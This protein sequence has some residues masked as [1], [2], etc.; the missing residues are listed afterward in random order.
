MGTNYLDIVPVSGSP[1]V[2]ASS[3]CVYQI[4]TNSSN[5]I[6]EDIEHGI[7]IRTYC[8]FFCNLP[9]LIMM[10]VLMT[11]GIPGNTL[12]I[13][14]YTCKKNKSPANIYMIALASLDLF[15]CV[16]IHPYI[17]WR[18]F[19]GYYKPHETICKIFE[20]FIHHIMGTQGLVLFAISVDRYICAKYPMQF[21]NAIT[22][23]KYFISAA[24]IVG[25]LLSAPSLWFLGI[26]M[27]YVTRGSTMYIGYRCDY[28]TEYY[29]S[30]STIFGIYNFFMITAFL[31]CC[32][33]AIVLY[34]LLARTILL[35]RRRV[36][37]LNELVPHR[38]SRLEKKEKDKSRHGEILNPHEKLSVEVTKCEKE[39]TCRN[40][41][42]KSALAS[43]SCGNH[44][45]P[46][47]LGKPS[48]NS[49]RDENGSD[50][51]SIDSF[52]S[53]TSGAKERNDIEMHMEYPVLES[54]D[55]EPSENMKKKTENKPGVNVK[56]NSVNF[57]LPCEDADDI[58]SENA[59]SSLHAHA[60]AKR[61][62]DLST[63]PKRISDLSANGKRIGA[64]P[65]H[66]RRKSAHAK[67]ISAVPAHGKRKDI[68]RKEDTGSTKHLSEATSSIKKGK[69]TDITWAISKPVISSVKR[70][71]ANINNND[72][73][74]LAANNS[75]KNHTSELNQRRP[76]VVGWFPRARSKGAKMLLIVS[77]VFLLSWMPFWIYRIGS[78]LNHAYLANLTSTSMT[79]W[80]TAFHCFFIN[81]TANPILYTII[82]KDFREECKKLYRNIRRRYT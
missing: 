35:R 10:S 25:T 79:I 82:H 12:V 28:S 20:Y 80:T 39:G 43:T 34:T 32:L 27:F 64:G 42:G 65:A 37:P 81:N 8:D 23:T 38:A 13:V 5:M 9:C 58:G 41:P 49:A 69:R 59:L 53:Q 36:Q 67:R 70:S 51:A 6:C 18:I 46:G 62:S 26:R 17:I 72:Q 45:K 71:V 7:E 48:G 63:H 66:G 77:L 76:F 29:K 33:I 68:N 47:V 4:N 44:Q 16:V 1:E 21:V 56:R 15:A 61:I 57:E 54:S 74:R 22:R 40:Q 55:T 60:Y 78:S 30:S 11:V 31:I 14:V 52:W 2:N 75:A 50:K 19:N 73:T 24:F 3:N